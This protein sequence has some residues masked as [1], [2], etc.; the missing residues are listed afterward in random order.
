MV[1]LVW[2][3]D[4]YSSRSLLS[5]PLS[6]F[7]D[8]RQLCCTRQPWLTRHCRGSRHTAGAVGSTCWGVW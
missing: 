1:N 7:R 3:S 5:L 8:K 6:A 4:H 2:V